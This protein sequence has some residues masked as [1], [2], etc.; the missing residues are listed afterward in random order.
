[1]LLSPCCGHWTP[2]IGDRPASA[3]LPTRV[4][5]IIFGSR[6]GRTWV[7]PLP[8]DWSTARGQVS[9]RP[10]GGEARGCFGIFVSPPIVSCPSLRGGSCGRGLIVAPYNLVSGDITREVAGPP[11]P[12]PLW[13]RPPPPGVCFCRYLANTPGKFHHYITE[14]LHPPSAQNAHSDPAKPLSLQHKMT[15]YVT[16]SPLLRWLA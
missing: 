9:R 13:P 16:V 11:T 10:S 7:L 2:N 12:T 4:T 6:Q 1:M 15:Q 14:N 5:S 3:T 8:V